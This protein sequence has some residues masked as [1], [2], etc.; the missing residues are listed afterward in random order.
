MKRIGAHVTI[1]GGV[2]NAPLHAQ[3]IGAKA[4]AMFT[5]NQRQ[6]QA[7]PYTEENILGFK[8]NLET[9]GILPK[10]VLPHDGYLI[11]LGHP[12]TDK[13]EQSRLAFLDE[14]RRCEQLGLTMLNFHP[15][16]HSSI[17]TWVIDRKSV[18]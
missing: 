9:A 3:S 8:S 5:K 12:E 1:S 10:Y 11:N 13:L 15:I 7:K 18:V 17:R 4:F 14:L 2:E 16:R 6:W